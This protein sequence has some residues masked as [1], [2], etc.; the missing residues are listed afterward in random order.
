MK[1]VMHTSAFLAMLMLL[2]IG[3][4]TAAGDL[5]GQIKN[6]KPGDEVPHAL[7]SFPNGDVPPLSLIH[8]DAYEGVFTARPYILSIKNDALL[9]AIIF[10]PRS[11][12]GA[13]EAAVTTLV[14]HKGLIRFSKLIANRSS[15]NWRLDALREILNRS[16]SQCS[17]AFIAKDAMAEREAKKAL[18]EIKT[19]LDKGASWKDAYGSVADKHPEGKRHK[20]EPRGPGTLVGYMYSGWVSADG[21]DFSSLHFTANVPTAFFADAIRS[22][23]GGKVVSAPNGFYL[24]Y[25]FELYLPGR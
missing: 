14:D 11:E 15:T 5:H 7:L 10:D 16:F 2:F 4:V 13:F 8:S 12:R 6:W 20:N 1:R 24:I 18:E 3:D 9:E 22:G 25:V 23:K 21:F 17:V 19:Q